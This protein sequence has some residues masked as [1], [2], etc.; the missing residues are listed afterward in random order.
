MSGPWW[1]T[2]SGQLAHRCPI[3]LVSV[4]AL[5]PPRHAKQGLFRDSWADKEALLL[6]GSCV[7]YPRPVIALYC[8]TL[9]VQVMQIAIHHQNI[10]YR[11]WNK[12]HPKKQYIIAASLWTHVHMC[13]YKPVPV[14]VNWR[15]LCYT[16]FLM[17]LWP[18]CT[19]S[20][21]HGLAH[22]RCSLSGDGCGCH[23]DGCDEDFH[24][25]SSRWES[26]E[27]MNK[28]SGRWSC[29]GRLLCFPSCGKCSGQ[30]KAIEFFPL[31]HGEILRGG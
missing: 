27:F 4:G 9:V 13:S 11:K 3:T 6:D 5:L 30:N 16:S 24:A 31:S 28:R 21:E 10:T 26:R 18:R 19:L 25:K 8:I 23:G 2:L 12:L 15:Q 1:E 22:H 29:Q 14:F 20:V 7:I 17:S